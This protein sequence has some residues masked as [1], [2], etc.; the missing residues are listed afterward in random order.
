M[1][2]LSEEIEALHPFR[3]RF[4]REA[5]D[6]MQ[7]YAAQGGR[8]FCGKGCSN[9]CRLAVHATLPEAAA[10]AESLNSAQ[11]DALADHVRSLRQAVSPDG[12]MQSY[13]RAHRRMGAS[14][15][16]LNHRGECGI[17]ERRPIAC[18]SLISTRNSDWCSVDLG[19]LHPLERQAFL[20]SLDPQVVDYPTHYAAFPRLTGERMEKEISDRMKAAVGFSVT[21]NFPLL[22]WLAREKKMAGKTAEEMRSFPATLSEEGFGPAVFLDRG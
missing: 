16:F 14:C 3:H 9:C 21:G 2:R 17:Y 10:V 11:S 8:L 7:R 6:W 5:G 13:L 12:D 20:S 1:W 19:S 15:P 4:D 18:R 22:V